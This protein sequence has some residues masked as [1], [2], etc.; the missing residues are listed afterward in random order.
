ML[1]VK[2]TTTF[3]ASTLIYVHCRTIS[4]SF[5]EKRWKIGEKNT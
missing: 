5:V 4:N 3:Q 1:K 2:V